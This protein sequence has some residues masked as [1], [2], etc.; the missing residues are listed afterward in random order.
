MDALFR[1]RID[2]GEQ[3]A[4]KLAHFRGLEGIV[5]AIP[6]GGVPVGYCVSSVLKWP[7][8]VILSK[9]IG[10]PLDPEY[11]IGSVSLHGYHVDKSKGVSNDYIREK[12]STI[13]QDLRRRQKWFTASREKL[14]LNDRVIIL[15]D[16]GIATG[17]TMI[18]C[19]KQLRSVDPKMIVVATPVAPPASA[20]RLKRIS[21]QVICLATPA[22]FIAIGRFYDS[23]DQL[24]DFEVMDYLSKAK[25]AVIH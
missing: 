20:T 11:A 16:D 13:R 6:R 24:S 22:E 25:D 5:L 15:V 12:I 9:K 3:L 18:S 14:E 10:H 17:N 19:I 7:M 2:A 4:R 8:E 1:N 23:F 21:D